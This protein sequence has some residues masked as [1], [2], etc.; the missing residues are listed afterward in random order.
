M[1][2]NIAKRTLPGPILIPSISSFETQCGVLDA[3]A[4]QAIFSEPITLISAFDVSKEPQL[5]VRAREFRAKGGIVFLDSGGYEFSRIRKYAGQAV[6][7]P[8]EKY[9]EV[10]S[11]CEFDLCASYDEF[12]EFDESIDAFSKR[13]SERLSLQ[14]DV[15]PQALVPVLHLKDY[16]GNRIL[17]W[18]EVERLLD[19]VVS[20]FE[21]DFVA[22][23]ERELGAGLNER[24][25][26]T[27]RIV[28]KLEQRKRA[29][30]LHILGCGNPLTYMVL[31]H[32]GMAMADGLEWC[33]TLIG[34]RYH[35]HHFQQADQFPEPESDVNNLAN[36]V[37]R[38][39]G[40][41]YRAMA[42]ARNLNALQGLATK[43]AAAVD[44]DTLP[45]LIRE[46]FG[47]RAAK[48]LE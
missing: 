20:H 37:I 13:L 21:P 39:V 35:L 5:A 26:L 15:G 45:E 19:S 18:H 7:W 40:A 8:F 16:D 25:D 4:L 10:R 33:R 14:R 29:T 1:Q 27:Q 32:A 31:S 28:A 44:S 46:I 38:S 47:V 6:E 36:E 9:M 24:Y 43:V 12:I 17:D 23:P 42:L 30:Q 41:N 48:L 22:I 34:E 11:S 3:I 2:V